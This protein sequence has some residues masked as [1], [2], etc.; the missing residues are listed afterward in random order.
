MRTDAQTLPINEKKKDRQCSGAFI[1]SS[2]KQHHLTRGP[3]QKTE[4]NHESEK[5]TQE[6]VKKARV[7]EEQ[8]D[9]LHI[10]DPM[11][12]EMLT[13]STGVN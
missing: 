8:E 3:G 5:V 4:W 11:E 13:P 7:H 6:T 2:D 10:I 1:F 9:T 12:C